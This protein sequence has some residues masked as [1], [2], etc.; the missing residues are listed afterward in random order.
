MKEK[1]IFF[2]FMV[3]A[4]VGLWWAGGWAQQLASA[5]S[6]VWVAPSPYVRHMTFG[7]HESVAD[8]LWIRLIQDFDV[9]NYPIEDSVIEHPTYQQWLEEAQ[10]EQ[11]HDLKVE[12]LERL[13][14][15][16]VTPKKICNY[17][18]PFYMLDAI[19]ELAPQ[20]LMPYMTGAVTLSVLVDDY[21]GAGIIFEKGVKNF[22]EEWG[23]LYRAAYHYM[24]DRHDLA[25]AAELLEQSARY[26]APHWVQSLAAR[27]YT[28]SGQAEVALGLLETYLTQIEPDNK[29]AR[30]EVQSRIQALKQI[31][32]EESD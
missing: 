9:C 20:F 28:V 23:L 19:T 18:W 1:L 26:G 15:A 11:A 17:S 4:F 3:G 5:K 13:A 6:K 10:Q 7:Y 25:R 24:Y 14:L 22:P 27:F 2:G 31:I 29:E 32:A 16:E 12:V 8:S 21:E 30:L